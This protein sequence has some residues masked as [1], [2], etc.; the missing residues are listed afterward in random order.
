[1]VTF[2]SDGRAELTAAEKKMLAE[3]E[4]L[5]VVYDEDSPELTDD[6]K[7]AFIAARK[8]KPFRRKPLT[9]YVS[10][11]TLEKI[12]SMGADHT[13]ILGKLFDKVVEEYQTV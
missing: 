2:E 11:A 3:A 6:M 8:K 4:K 7:K 9:I 12:E 5:P 10:P 1:M 13:A